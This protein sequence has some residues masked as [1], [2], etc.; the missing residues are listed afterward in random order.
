MDALINDIAQ[1]ERTMEVFMKLNLCLCQFNKKK[2]STKVK[3]IFVKS[4]FSNHLINER[5]S[6]S[7]NII[8]GI[9]P[10]DDFE[11]QTSIF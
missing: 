10:N 2:K 11:D 5:W 4:K 1:W 7:L 9:I 8:N 6:P 3:H